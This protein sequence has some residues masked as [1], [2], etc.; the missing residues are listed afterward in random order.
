MIQ[1]IRRNRT[2]VTL[3]T[4]WLTL[5]VAWLITGNDLLLLLAL[6]VAAFGLGLVVGQGTAGATIGAGHV[7]IDA[8]TAKKL[9]ETLKTELG[10]LTAK[11]PQNPPDRSRSP[12]RARK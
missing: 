7:T 6:T 10:N 5:E 4:L 2:H 1:L 3:I 11:D 8:T 9:R 12:G